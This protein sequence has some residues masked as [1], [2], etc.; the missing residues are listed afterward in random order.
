MQTTPTIA[1][2]NRSWWAHPAL[3]AAGFILLSV[4]L[5]FPYLGGGF[6]ADDFLLLNLLREEPVRFSWWKGFWSVFDIPALDSIWWRDP[7]AG[8]IFWR[9]VSTWVIAGSVALFGEQPLPLHLLALLLH[10]VNAFLLYAIILR[11]SRRRLLALLT[12]LFFLACEDHS[13]V[14]GWITTITDILCLCFIALGL[15]LYLL[16]LARR[17]VVALAGALLLTLLALGSKESAAVAPLLMILTALCFPRGAAPAGDEDLPL[18]RRAGETLRDWASWAPPLLFLIVF[19]ALYHGAG[20][21]QMS[22]LVYTDPI[23]Q[24]DPYLAQLVLHLPVMWLATLSPVFPSLPMFWPQHL[25]AAAL[26]GLLLFVLWMWALRPLLRRPLVLWGLIGY[27]LALLPQLGAGASERA[28]YVPMA[29]AAVVLAVT[30]AQI[31]PLAARAGMARQRFFPTRLFGWLTILLVLL[32]GL[33]LSAAY[34]PHLLS[35]F[36]KPERHALT[37]RGEIEASAAEAILVLNT[38]GPFDT[39][40]LRIALEHHLHRRVPLYPLCSCNAVVSVTRA[41]PAAFVVRADRPGWLGNLFAKIFRTR[42]TLE[43]GM[44][45]ETPFFSAVVLE[46]APSGND[47]LAVRFEFPR[48]LDDPRLLFLT[49]DGRRYRRIDLT[50]LP[51]GERRELADTSDIWASM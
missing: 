7:G 30:L 27:H 47:V 24:P 39:L 11:L 22:N 43:A 46:T 3:L 14:I 20:L 15:R 42:E 4:L 44:R 17:R 1:R 33:V 29:A 40:Y 13:L 16:W 34:P 19:L 2:A 26:G 32:P 31:R 48:P 45:Y 12:G 28:A 41:G 50:A 36:A 8:G 35:S 10:G 6:H 5:N 25:H 9:P 49:W 21:G 38:S 37:A 23:K 51:E 18:R